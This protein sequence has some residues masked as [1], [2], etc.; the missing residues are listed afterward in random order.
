LSKTAGGTSLKGYVNGVL[1]AQATDSSLAAGMIGV[2]G[3]RIKAAF[4][5]VEAR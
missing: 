2:Y 4:D 5:N 1:Q 3:Y